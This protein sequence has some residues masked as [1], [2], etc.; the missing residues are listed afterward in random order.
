HI[1]GHEHK[2]EHEHKHKHKHSYV[3][4]DTL[5]KME[6]LKRMRKIMKYIIR[7]KMGKNE[8]KSY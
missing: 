4:Q 5:E 2:L 1:H 8:V 7:R 3:D 6:I